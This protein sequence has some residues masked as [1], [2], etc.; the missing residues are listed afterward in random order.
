MIALARAGVSVLVVPLVGAGADAAHLA[1][2][3]TAE[4][5]PFE[6][7]QGGTDTWRACRCYS[8]RL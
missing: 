1:A 3:W 5:V 2:P 4:S 7:D 8:G 6:E